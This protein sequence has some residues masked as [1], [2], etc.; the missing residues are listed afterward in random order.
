MA[1]IQGFSRRNQTKKVDKVIKETR[2]RSKM[3]KFY[4]KTLIL[5]LAGLIWS[6]CAV[7]FAVEFDT[8]SKCTKIKK[9]CTKEHNYEDW[10]E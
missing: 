5:V 4:V 10:Y 7:Y 8:C 1:N 2:K 9:E 6:G 3:E